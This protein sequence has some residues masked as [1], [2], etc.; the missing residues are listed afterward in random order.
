[1]RPKKTI[2]V[3]LLPTLLACASRTTTTTDERGGANSG[4][5][6]IT[7]SVLG[8][9]SEDGEV[10]LALFGS[11]EDF[12]MRTNPVAAGRVAPAGGKAVW[13]IENLKAGT[14]ALAVYQDLNGNG[15]LDRTF[16]GPPDE[17]YGFS[18]DARGSFGPPSF[19][20]AAIDLGPAHREIEIR[21][22]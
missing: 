12:R 11:A 21:L 17:P 2:A 8:L 13:R 3:L 20:E 5:E 1:M 18:N 7:V 10:V 16:P 14:Y 15:K 6:M 4:T 19:R 22:R 9:E